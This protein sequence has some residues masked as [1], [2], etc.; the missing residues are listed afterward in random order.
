[1]EGWIILHRSIFENR[2]YFADPFTRSSAW[3]DI[4]L[5]AAHKPTTRFIRDVRVEIGVGE[6][7]VSE[8]FL[9]KR[10][11]WS[12]TKVRTFLGLLKTEAQIKAARSSICTVIKVLNWDKHQN[13]KALKEAREKREKSA[14]KANTMNGNNGNNKKEKEKVFSKFDPRRVGAVQRSDHVWLKDIEVEKLVEK[15]G[16]AALDAMIHKLDVTIALKISQT[17]KHQYKNHYAAI[18]AWVVEWYQ[19]NNKGGNS[20][21]GQSYDVDGE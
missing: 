13:L 5:M 3:V 20:G 10:W 21:Y 18:R 17:G 11:K 9:A 8:R 7:A 15:Y 2:L 16:K 4:L 12:T 1:M 6:L 14:R 19:K